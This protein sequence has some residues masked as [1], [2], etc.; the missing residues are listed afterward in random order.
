LVPFYSRYQAKE[1]STYL[2]WYR[3]RQYLEAQFWLVR[4]I[5]EAQGINNRFRWNFDF[6]D[7]LPISRVGLELS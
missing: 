6:D 4:K 5:L 1:F 3:Q 2:H 7:E